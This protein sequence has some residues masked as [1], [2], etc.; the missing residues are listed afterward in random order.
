MA[1]R[2]FVVN[3][4]DEIL[5]AFRDILEDAGYEVVLSGIAYKSADEVIHVKPDLI[6]LDYIFGGEKLGWQLLQLLKMHRETA[7]IP[8]IICTAA[9]RDVRD[10]EGQ[11]KAVGVRVVSKPFDIDDLLTAVAEALASPPFDA[12]TQPQLEAAHNNNSQRDD[13]TQPGQPHR[14]RRRT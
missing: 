14:R 9:T 7:H 5:Q 2:I 12:Y 11:L 1:A 13:E 6:I 10:I 8:V 3:D 4:T